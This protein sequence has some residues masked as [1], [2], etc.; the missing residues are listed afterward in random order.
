MTE[1]V[2]QGIHIIVELDCNNFSDK[3]L[4]VI[5]NPKVSQIEGYTV[6]KLQPKEEDK[7]V[8]IKLLYSNHE[9]EV[10]RKI[11]GYK[12][13]PKMLGVSKYL[14]GW[15]LVLEK[16][17]PLTYDYFINNQNK[18]LFSLIN[19]IKKLHD[20][21]VIHR[22]IKMKNILID[23]GEVYLC[24]F[25][26]K[27]YTETHAASEI[28]NDLDFSIKSDIY[29]LGCTIYELVT[30]LQPWH[31]I[32]DFE[33]YVN[34]NDFA[35]LFKNVKNNLYRNIIEDCLIKRCVEKKNLDLLADVFTRTQ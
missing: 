31:D 25:E 11:K 16:M 26:D 18:I 21:G 22:D 2:L 7:E 34:K 6:N 23:D 24:D 35:P 30:G 10:Y 1:I 27:G 17:N 19:K 9:L 3:K 28:L 13:A 33:P 14:G 15:Y 32:E 12:I 29:S 4:Y 5:N 8:F 20:L